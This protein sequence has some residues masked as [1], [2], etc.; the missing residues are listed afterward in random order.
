MIFKT[1]LV[2]DKLCSQPYLLP[3]YK[4]LTSY[5]TQSSVLINISHKSL[6]TLQQLNI[7][8]SLTLPIIKLCKVIGIMLHVI[9]T[10]NNLCIQ[11]LLI[12]SFIH[13]KYSL[14][15][16]NF[17]YYLANTPKVLCGLF[18]CMMDENV[19]SSLSI[20]FLSL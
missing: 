19:L 6:N 20:S 16:H 8:I 3:S 13:L 7:K 2:D 18:F 1:L 10:Q 11:I 17:L 9:K 15:F 14:F 12:C 5:C 4:R